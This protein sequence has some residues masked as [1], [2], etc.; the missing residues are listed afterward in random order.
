MIKQLLLALFLG[1]AV[2]GPAC[3]QPRTEAEMYEE[4]VQ[5]NKEWLKTI[6]DYEMRL[7][8]R[9]KKLNNRVTVTSNSIL[10]VMV[11]L[12]MVAPFWIHWVLNRRGIAVSHGASALAAASGGMDGSQLKKLQ[13]NQI[14]LAEILISVE[15]LLRKTDGKLTSVAGE[16]QK[17]NTL[18][19]E[20]RQAMT[21]LDE[22]IAK[23]DG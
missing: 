12:F 1:L 5:A 22:Q 13:A 3:A 11:V 18:L 17:I 23:G 7:Y 8:E 4:R 15:D 9:I 10:I 14:V 16:R 20:C 21:A 19:A 2:A 6:P